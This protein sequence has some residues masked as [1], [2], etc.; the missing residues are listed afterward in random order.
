MEYQKKREEISL[1]SEQLSG[2]QELFWTRQSVFFRQIIF[3]CNKPRWLVL[4]SVAQLH[5]PNLGSVNQVTTW[6]KDWIMARCL[7]LWARKLGKK[8]TTMP[9]DVWDSRP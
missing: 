7:E 9:L 5:L 1:Q 4:I 2:F 6:S 3:S 8:Q